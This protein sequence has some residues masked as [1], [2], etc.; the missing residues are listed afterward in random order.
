MVLHQRMEGLL[1]PHTTMLLLAMV[2]L[3]GLAL[4]RSLLRPLFKYFYIRRPGSGAQVVRVLGQARNKEI[5]ALQCDAR[6]ICSA[7]SP[8]TAPRSLGRADCDMSTPAVVLPVPLQAMCW[9]VSRAT[10]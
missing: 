2:A 6:D 9:A 4:Y 1:T 3:A 10:C 8:P 7:A 5:R